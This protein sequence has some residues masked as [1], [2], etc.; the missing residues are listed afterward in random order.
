[1][2]KLYLKRG[3]PGSGKSTSAREMVTKDG[4]TVRINFDDLRA[5]LFNGKWSPQRERTL[6]DMCKGMIVSAREF[7]MNVIIDNTNLTQGHV[8]RYKQLARQSEMDFVEQRHDTDLLEC[9]R[10]D[11]IRTTGHVG[12]AVIE[13]LAYS[14]G[15]L[16]WVDTKPL[17]IFDVDGT[18]AD[19]SHRAK[20]FLNIPSGNDGQLKN[21]W[22]KFFAAS[23]DDN[24]IEAVQKWA[25]EIYKSGQYTLVIC[26][27]RSDDY[28]DVTTDWLDKHEIPFHH[29]FMR[30][31]GDKR[32]DSIVK[33]EILNFL[34]K[35]QIVGIV[36]DRQQ[37]IDMWRRVRQAEDLN[38]SVYQ[39]AEGNF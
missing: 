31:R 30:R 29:I 32:E 10:R 8:E 21:E 20:E 22:D 5:S 12:R 25:Q 15:W 9:V 37:V 1:M 7:G 23:K 11:N 14:S 36:D 24:P 17:W 27:G 3:L 4:N 6:N 38:Y 2:S 28:C 34:P 39:V 35:N 13:R 33:Q 18:L 19:S 16:Q 26:S